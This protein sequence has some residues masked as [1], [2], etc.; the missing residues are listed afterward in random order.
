[1]SAGE[2]YYYGG[3]LRQDFTPKPAY[4][5]VRD[6][7]KKEWHTELDCNTDNGEFEF[8]GFYGDYELEISTGE[9]TV[10]R[11]ISLKKRDFLNFKVTL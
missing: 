6:L 8:K 11:N 1:M 7:F 9:K 3:L 2:N 10:I 5:V 4:Y